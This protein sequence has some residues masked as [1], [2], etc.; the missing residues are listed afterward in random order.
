[1]R[2][3]DSS[4]IAMNPTPGKTGA[5]VQCHEHAEPLDRCDGAGKDVAVV[6]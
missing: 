3:Q 6:Q 4:G 5:V 2:R 1:M